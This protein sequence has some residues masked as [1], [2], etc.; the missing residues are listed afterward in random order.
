MLSRVHLQ[1]LYPGSV[2][3]PHQGPQYYKTSCG[4]EN[5]AIQLETAIVWLDLNPTKCFPS[6]F[7]KH[8]TKLI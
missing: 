6:V 8:F 3:S 1:K 7:D 4:E 2:N 5:P